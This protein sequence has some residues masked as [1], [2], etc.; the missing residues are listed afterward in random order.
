[1]RLALGAGDPGKHRS[2]GLLFSPS[3]PMLLS[4]CR[5]VHLNKFGGGRPHACGV[6]RATAWRMIHITRSQKQQR[7]AGRAVQTAMCSNTNKWY[8]Q[9]EQCLRH[10]SSDVVIVAI[11]RTQRLSGY[12]WNELQGSVTLFWHIAHPA[13]WEHMRS[14]FENCGFNLM[15]TCCLVVC[16]HKCV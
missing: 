6:H 14:G 4:V 2:R 8:V 1:M 16:M 13:A 15:D 7:T 11:C 10:D 9:K 12:C 3:N 5:F